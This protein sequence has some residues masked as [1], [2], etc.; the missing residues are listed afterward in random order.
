MIETSTKNAGR[1]VL[2][3][4]F[5]IGQRVRIDAIDCIGCCRRIMVTTDGVEYLI[6]YFDDDKV[7]REEYMLA[8]ELSRP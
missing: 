7:R 2:A 8:Q 1:N 5:T 3:F 6:A 4:D